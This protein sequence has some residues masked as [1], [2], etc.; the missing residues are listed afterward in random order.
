LKNTSLA[1]LARQSR[2][3]RCPLLRNFFGLSEEYQ[4]SLYE[5][6]FLLQYYGGW[7]FIELY[8]L[9]VGLRNWYM[10]RLAKEIKQEA[11][12]HKK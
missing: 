3:W 2:I 12:R 9:P 7:S 6:L 8:N 11:E 1:L 4:K 5:Q 10:D